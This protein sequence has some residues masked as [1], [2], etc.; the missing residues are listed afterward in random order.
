MEFVK[1]LTVICS[2]ITRF[3]SY[4]EKKKKSW[5]NASTPN[6]LFCMTWGCHNHNHS[7][8][9]DLVPVQGASPRC[10]L[11]LVPVLVPA[12]VP[13]LVLELVQLTSPAPHCF[14]SVT[15]LTNPRTL[16]RWLP[17]TQSPTA[18]PPKYHAKTPLVS[19]FHSR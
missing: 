13:V 1:I 17:E 16:L 11:V 7:A 3:W 2:I 5:A 10:H 14:S 15:P 12:L 18:S 6:G 19:Q 8:I 4:R 9:Q